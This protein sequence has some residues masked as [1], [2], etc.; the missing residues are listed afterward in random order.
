M[1]STL[2]GASVGIESIRTLAFVGPSAA[3]KTTLAEALLQRSGAI[4]AAGSIERGSTVSDHDPLE[5]RMQ[6]SLNASVMHLTHADTRIHFIDT[7][8]GPDFLGQS[9][10]ALEAVETAAIVINASTGI[11]PMAQRMMDYAASRHL[12][13]IVVVNK[14]DAA[15]VDLPG[16]LAQIQAA[17]GKEC[18][19]LNLPDAGGT[20]VVDCFY[21]REGHSDFGSVDAAHRA[22]VEQVVEVDGD[23]VDRYLNDGDVDAS[24]LHKPLEQA[25]REGH[26]IPVCFVSARTGA[27]VAELLDVIVKLLPNPTESNP[28]E[29][30]NGEG[31]A[32]VPMQAE[33]D[34]AK[35]VLAHVFKVTVDPYVGK[36]GIFR[37]HQGT[38]Q[39][40]QMLYVGDGRKP[41]KVTHLYLLQGKEHVEVARALPGD[42]VAVPKVDELH[43]DAV[44]HD[45]AEDD[46]I[47]LKPLDF[48]VP[49]H[50]LAIGPKRHGDEQR[51]W[52][53]LG[54]LIDE[55][56]C[57]KVEH[58]ATT[59][60]TVIYGLGEL[61]L[62]TLLE[63]LREVY[64]FEV[65]TRPPR[66]AYRETITANAEGH[67]R[68]KKQTGG[69]GQFGE[70]FLK[71]EPLPRGAGFE[72]LDQV[73]GG[74]IPNQFIPAVEKGVREVL[75][76]GAIAGYPVVDVRVIVYDGKS[77]S[78]DS[79]EIAFATAGRKAFMAAIREA[80]PI[81]LEPIVTIE[82]VAPDSAM[83]DITG[84]LSAKRGL[85]TGTANAASGT[86]VI[87]GQVPMSELSG[88][89]SRLNA[90]TAGQ[91]RYT[92]ELSHYDPVPPTVQQQ[93]QS[94]HQ[95]KEDD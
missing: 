50:G 47:H 69:A 92:I 49:V 14:I 63:R 53:I 32:A 30:L 90:M 64:K 48:P 22:L 13:R 71:V 74:V 31:A 33:P 9:L 28:P 19:P 6:H 52:E 43:F 82:I 55:D 67:H 59:N 70:V 61:H 57:L 45:A 85:V 24:E 56:P 78:V 40:N 75:A 26:L 72:F 8:G 51:M 36:M 80:R 94:Q 66:I 25:L 18:L 41:F 81:V 89:Q 3:G 77:H 54:K 27:G 68:H 7:P 12:D 37:V 34:P 76:G 29:F 20:K 73:K 21:N 83:G 16:L 91:G 11:E 4:G 93:L 42:I 79:K 86:V 60:E 58:I 5:K 35:H 87:R 39:Q 23:F 95:V 62:R 2:S 46:H 1:P 15:G 84:D 44:L 17:F 88:Y 10:P 65:T 38:V